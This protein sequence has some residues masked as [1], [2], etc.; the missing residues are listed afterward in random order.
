ME[1][2]IADAG[3]FT[4]VTLTA[5]GGDLAVYVQSRELSRVSLD[6]TLAFDFSDD[7]GRGPEIIIDR[8][9]NVLRVIRGR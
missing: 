7:I 3:K 9:G 1:D 6:A 8:N 5:Q 2:E 4:E